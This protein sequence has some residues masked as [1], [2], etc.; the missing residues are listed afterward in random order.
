[1]NDDARLEWAHD[2]CRW[3]EGP[4]YLPAWRQLIWSDIPN[5]RMLGW[6]EATG[7]VSHTHAAAGH[8]YLADLATITAGGFAP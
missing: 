4:L 8:V 7:T 1:M 3:I 6:A 5:D 2:S